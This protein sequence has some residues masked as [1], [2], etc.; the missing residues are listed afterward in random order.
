MADACNLSTLGVQGG[1]ITWAQEF[2]T[3]LA[4]TVKPRFQQNTKISQPPVFPATWE[5][6]A[7]ESLEP[8]K[9][10]LQWAKTVPLHSRLGD[11][12]RPHVKKKKKKT[13]IDVYI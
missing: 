13:V 7:G 1:Q 8:T 5:A 6:G 9:Q 4:N 11:G 10:R 2:K 12:V 3:S